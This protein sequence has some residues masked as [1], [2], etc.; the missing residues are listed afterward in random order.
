MSLIIT[1]T[2]HLPDGTLY[3]MTLI[4]GDLCE[5]LVMELIVGPGS[6][7]LIFGFFAVCSGDMLLLSCLFPIGEST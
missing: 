4:T 7:T 3:G 1:N 6:S 2:W 5:L